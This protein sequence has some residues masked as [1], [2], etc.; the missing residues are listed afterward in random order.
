LTANPN[1]SLPQRLSPAQAI[2]CSDSHDYT[3]EQHAFDMGLMDRFPE[4][5]ASSS[6]PLGQVVDYFDGNTVTALWNYAQHF[7]MSDNSFCGYGTRLPFLVVSPWAKQNYVDHGVTDQTSIIH[8]IEDNWSLG[9]IGDFS[10]DALSGS[11]EGL[12][13]FNSDTRAP[14]LILDPATGQVANS[15][16]DN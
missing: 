16:S 15:G 3:D 9:R 5:T 11:L 8:F 6:C 10:F 12:F 7:A 14:L 4:S 1:S 13:D 2:V